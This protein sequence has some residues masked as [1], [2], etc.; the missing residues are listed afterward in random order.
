MSVIIHTA[1]RSTPDHTEVT[2]HAEIHLRIRV[3]AEDLYL[4]I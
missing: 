1:H 2:I 4:T 3:L